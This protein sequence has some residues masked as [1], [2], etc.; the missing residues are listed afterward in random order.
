[1][2]SSSPSHTSGLNMSWAPFLTPTTNQ[3]PRFKPGN[4]PLKSMYVP[5]KWRALW[6]ILRQTK[7]L[8]MIKFQPK[9]SKNLLKF[10]VSLSAVLQ[11]IF[12]L[13]GEKVPPSW[14]LGKI[15][16]VHK[17]DCTLTKTNYHPIT[18]L[19]VLSK[20]FEKLVH[21]RL[22]PHF[23]DVYHNNVFA[24]RDYHGCDAAMLSLTEQFKK[25][26]EVISLVSMDQSKAFDTLPH[27]L[28]VKK[29]EDYGG[30]SKVINL[31]TNYLS[32][33][34]QRVR[35]CGQ[36]SSMKT[37]LKVSPRGSILGPILFNIF[38]NDLSYAIDE[39]TFT[40]AD[41]T[42]LFKSVEDIDQV[43]HAI[44]ADLKKVEEWY[45]FNQMKRNHSKY[46]AIPYITFGR[47]ERNPVLTCEGT[48]I[49]IQDEMELLG[50]TLGNKLIS[51][52]D[53]FVKSVIKL[54][55]RLLF[56]MVWRK[57]CLLNWG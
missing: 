25:E 24:H 56:S 8:D 44:N 42:Q 9:P 13:K 20:V 2:C 54:V 26:Y 29:L 31:I 34:Q 53:R 14:K 48:V 11:W 36:H 16:A 3:K 37:M 15:V 12:Y 55:N 43:E 33:W 38:M 45:E 1:M 30:D 18:I 5:L 21:S 50:I 46:Q 17:K 49:P 4:P 57:Y 39:C 10:R 27:D 51:L 7:L 41:N 47:V 35:L 52:R 28:I 23:E 22:A 32:D 19:P 40:Y 6:R